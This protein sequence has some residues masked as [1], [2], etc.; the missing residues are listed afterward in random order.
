MQNYTSMSSACK[1]KAKKFRHSFCCLGLT[2]VRRRVF[3]YQILALL[4]NIEKLRILIVC[5]WKSSILMSVLF[6]RYKCIKLT[7]FA[8]TS[9]CIKRTMF[10]IIFF[11]VTNLYGLCEN[12]YV[13]NFCSLE[14]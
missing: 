11:C 3:S 1:A 10:I 12:T 2:L 13:K 9:Y 6:T 4:L 5:Q 14:Y 7:K 8:N